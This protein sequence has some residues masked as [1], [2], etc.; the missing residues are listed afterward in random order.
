MGQETVKSIEMD[1]ERRLNPVAF[2]ANAVDIWLRGQARG[3]ASLGHW[4]FTGREMDRVWDTGGGQVMVWGANS[5]EKVVGI[6]GNNGM[7]DALERFAR[8]GCDVN[9]DRLI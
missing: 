3:I 6:N 5:H 1:D 7:V 8:L 9:R 4:S 2:L